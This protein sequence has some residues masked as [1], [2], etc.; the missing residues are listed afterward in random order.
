LSKWEKRYLEADSPSKL[1][2]EEFE[3]KLLNQQDNIQQ[4]LDYLIQHPENVDAR[5][6]DAF[7]W[8]HYWRAFIAFELKRGDALKLVLKSSR[9]MDKCFDHR[10]GAGGAIPSEW[11]LHSNKIRELTTAIT[12][13]IAN[14]NDGQS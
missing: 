13:A 9:F 10:A 4:C 14:M 2:L 8:Y 6:W 7:A 12:E 11:N 5:N 1:D 3:A